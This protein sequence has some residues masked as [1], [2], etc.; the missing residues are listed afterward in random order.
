MALT[1]EH[2]RLAPLAKITPENMLDTFRL[3]VVGAC[4]AVKHS[5]KALSNSSSGSVVLFSSVAAQQGFPMHAD[6]GTSKAALHG[7]TISL[8]AE[9]AG[10]IRVNCIAPSLTN[11]PLASPLL[12]NEGMLKAIKA[13]HP[14]P[15][16]GEAEDVAELAHFLM[17]D[18]SGWMT[19]QV[20]GVDGG[21]STLRHKNQ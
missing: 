16:V 21:R 13:A 18:K 14:I 12:S 8:A 15:R 10:K 19:G 11:T 4:M 6:I 5:K 7:L 9:L 3:N 20:I 17:S 1:N 2:I